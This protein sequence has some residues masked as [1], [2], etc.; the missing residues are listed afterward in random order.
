MHAF[1]S[2]LF[3]AL[4]Y[5]VQ[6]APSPRIVGGKD[7]PIGKYPYQI[8]FRL[9]DS[10]T[11]GGSIIDNSNVLTAAHCVD[12]MGSLLSY[13]T[14][15]AGTNYLNQSGD[16]YAVK[17]VTIN[18]NYNS[19]LIINDI[20]LIH[21]ATPI[22]YNT[23]VQPIKL[24]TSDKNLEGKPCTLSGWGTTRLGGSA[25]NNLQEIDLIIY[26]QQQCK[27]EHSNLIYSHI[28]T[29]TKAGEGACHGDSGGPLVANGSQVGIVS[30]GRP[31]AVGYPDVYTR[32][33]SFIS[34]INENLKK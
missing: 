18:K 7:A 23:V 32:V 12:G 19:A 8:S 16:S 22:K 5:V 29:L 13:A 25:P 6:G 10:H 28:C 3:V 11:C 31:C 14:I 30:F 17:S 2:L 20:A 1:I 33:S 26:P 21:L 15:H 27:S 4:I 9:F 34:W 24:A